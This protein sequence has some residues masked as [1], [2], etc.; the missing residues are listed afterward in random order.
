MIISF[1]LI[2]VEKLITSGTRFGLIF[3][4]LG[5]AEKT[6]ANDFFYTTSAVTFL[7]T[8][9]HLGTDTLIVGKEIKAEG[10]NQIFLIRFASLLIAI[11]L[12]LLLFKFDIDF[13][14]Y[15]ALIFALLGASLPIKQLKA[16]SST[17]RK[18]I[19]TDRTAPEITCGLLRIIGMATGTSEADILIILFF[20]PEI[21][22][23]ILNSASLLNNKVSLKFYRLIIFE[24]EVN[25]SIIW[26][27]ITIF[28]LYGL[29]RG[30]IFIIT[31][32]SESLTTSAERILK[33]QQFFDMS[34]LL[35]VACIPLIKDYVKKDKSPI[36]LIILIGALGSL[37][38]LIALELFN[39]NKFISNAIMYI[40][41]DLAFYEISII[42]GLGL[43][44]YMSIM[45]FGLTAKYKLISSLMIGCLAFKVLCFTFLLKYGYVISY[46][47]ASATFFAAA[48][49]LAIFLNKS[50]PSN[51]PGLK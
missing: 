30:D 29:Q 28:S 35:T 2:V 7:I 20:A 25:Y 41:G 11:L 24:K 3:F 5:S 19:L 6:I 1:L 48:F 47:F 31:S 32:S 15:M 34:G 36:A 27:A 18:K 23:G 50:Y 12:L 8:L 21:I 49:I 37:F 22:C 46:S 10:V 43:I 51:K 4:V 14:T 13:V 45:Y 44:T 38:S 39:L 33:Y 26:S 17:D 40:C 42:F 16:L 9:C